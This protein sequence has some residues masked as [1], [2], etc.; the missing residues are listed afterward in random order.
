MN[1]RLE[2]HRLRSRLDSA[3]GRMATLPPDPEILA[4]YSKYLCVLVSGFIEQSLFE[5]MLEYARRNG[6][7]GLQRYVEG[8]MRRVANTKTQRILDVAGSFDPEFRSALEV[9]M[10]DER[11][12]AID[13]VV[14]LRNNI[15]HGRPVGVTPVRI[16]NYYDRVTEV[17]DHMLDVCIPA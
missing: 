15:A 9:F 13:S 17:V 6:G 12:D 10:V 11:K 4:D 8:Q 5:I 2:V 1:G 16:K 14:D 3:F 7:A